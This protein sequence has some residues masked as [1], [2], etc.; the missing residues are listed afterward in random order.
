VIKVFTNIERL[1]VYK[2]NYASEINHI[3]DEYDAKAKS[4]LCMCVCTHKVQYSV[5]ALS[6]TDWLTVDRPIHRPSQPAFFKGCCLLGT[7][8]HLSNIDTSFAMTEPRTSSRH[9]QCWMQPFC[10]ITPT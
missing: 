8:L 4:D 5:Q 1:T 3:S 7:A 6:L 9:S 2:W 10:T